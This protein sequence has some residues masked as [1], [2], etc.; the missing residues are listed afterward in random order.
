LGGQAATLDVGRGHRLERYYHH[1][2]MS[3]RHI[4]GLCEE[5]GLGDLVEWRP[6]SVAFFVDGRSRPFT[7]PLDLLRFTPL[8]LRA[9]LRMGLS[10][11]RLQRSDADVSAY[12]GRRP[13][14]GSCAR[15]APSPTR[16]SGARCCG[17]SS[18]P[19]RTRSRWP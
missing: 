16:S 19:V 8:S 3:D 15:W 17:R 6:S 4:V 18:D 12:E 5:L 1:W 9:R 2:F 11:V 14:S 7:T 13:A 10:V